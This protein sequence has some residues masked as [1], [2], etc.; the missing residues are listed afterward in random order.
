MTRVPA[1]TGGLP[2]TTGGGGEP[3]RTPRSVLVERDG[4][5]AGRGLSAE[6]ALS[7]RA[8]AYLPQPHQEARVQ[9]EEPDDP[10][11]AHHGGAGQVPEAVLGD[12]RMPSRSLKAHVK[13]RNER[14]ERSRPRCCRLSSADLETL[15]KNM[16]TTRRLRTR[17]RPPCTN[18]R[19]TGTSGLSPRC[20]PPARPPARAH[21]RLEARAEAEEPG[22][23][24]GATFRPSPLSPAQGCNHRKGSTGLPIG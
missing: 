1:G 15:L 14:G 11:T 9:A 10:I 7:P 22:A 24:R 16:L 20:R 2:P 6:G 5:D 13:D 8:E 12:Q 21:C 23:G 3:P 18:H 4:G 17:A 19:Q